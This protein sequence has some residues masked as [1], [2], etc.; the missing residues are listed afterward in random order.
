[1][2]AFIL[3]TRA[4]VA[5]IQLQSGRGA[6]LGSSD[7]DLAP[8]CLKPLLDQKC[9]KTQSTVAHG[10]VQRLCGLENTD[11]RLMKELR[12]WLEERQ[13]KAETLKVES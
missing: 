10:T 4:G 2:G 8:E 13:G 6:L 11:R 1:V 9:A 3:V 5:G 12:E 7:K